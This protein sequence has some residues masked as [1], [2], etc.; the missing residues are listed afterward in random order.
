MSHDGRQLAV[1]VQHVGLRD[2]CAADTVIVEAFVKG[3]RWMFPDFNYQWL[4]DELK[5]SVPKV[6]LKPLSCFASW[7]STE[8]L[9]G[10][11]ACI[12][13][14]CISHGKEDCHHPVCLGGFTSLYVG[15]WQACRS[16]WVPEAPSVYAFSVPRATLVASA[17]ILAFAANIFYAVVSL[18]LPQDTFI[19]SS[20][21]LS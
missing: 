7:L 12:C 19:L 6:L 2:T 16:L 14:A 17:H 13:T 10:W 9:P 11:T 8:T 15:T 18:L 4:I 1:K 5:E 20:A 3:L 21:Q